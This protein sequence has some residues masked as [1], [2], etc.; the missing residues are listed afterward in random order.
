MFTEK[1][2]MSEVAAL[3][4]LILHDPTLRNE[5]VARQR[6][7]RTRYL[8]ASVADSFDDLLK[9]LSGNKSQDMAL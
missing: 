7:V 8:Q 2:K 4:R 3:A 5:L 6:H 1:G 9:K